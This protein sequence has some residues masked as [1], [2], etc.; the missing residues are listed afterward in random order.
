ML[1]QNYFSDRDFTRSKRGW[2]IS[3]NDETQIEYEKK[4]LKIEKHTSKILFDQFLNECKK[5]ELEHSF[6]SINTIL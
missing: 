4:L 1:N 5:Y 2:K 3:N 6:N